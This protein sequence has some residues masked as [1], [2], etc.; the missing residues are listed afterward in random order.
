MASSLVQTLPRRVGEKL[1]HLQWL[2][3]LDTARLVASWARAAPERL[4]REAVEMARH[5][6]RWLLT[7]SVGAQLFACPSCEGMLVFDRGLRCSACSRELVRSRF[8]REAQLAWFGLMPPIGIDSLKRLGAQLRERAPARHV[9]GR[10]DATGHYLLVP[11]L[12]TYP[13]E[14]PSTF[15]RVSYLQEIFSLRGMPAR[16]VSHTCHMLHD[17]VMCLFSSGQWRREMTCREA[18]QQRAYPH[19]VKLLNYANGKADSFAI[20]TR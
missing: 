17:D 13:A 1:E 10:S 7:A 8:P 5:F 11:L 12:A 14:F 2:L 16:G 18:L 15:P 3:D 4:E 20:V 6:P 19:V 9:V